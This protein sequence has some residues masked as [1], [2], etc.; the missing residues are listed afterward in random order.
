LQYKLSGGELVLLGSG[1]QYFIGPSDEQW[2]VVML[3]RQ[4]SVE[5]FIAFASNPEYLAGIGHR[6]AAISDSRLLPIVEYKD[7]KLL[8]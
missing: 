7:H 2:D 4:N 1:G 5:S 6:T 8:K 3:V